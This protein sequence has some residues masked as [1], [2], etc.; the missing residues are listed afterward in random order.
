MDQV[1]IL[2][3]MSVEQ[4]ADEGLPVDEAMRAAIAE[5]AER[6]GSLHLP[7]RSYYFY[8]LA[9]VPSNARSNGVS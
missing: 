7:A 3:Y 4:L 8:G 5:T 6:G 2:D 9:L 1:S